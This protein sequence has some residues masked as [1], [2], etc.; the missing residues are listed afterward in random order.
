MEIAMP[1]PLPIHRMK[2][3]ALTVPF[4]TLSA[5]ADPAMVAELQQDEQNYAV[6]RDRLYDEQQTGNTAAALADERNYKLAVIKLREDRGIV[7]GPNA[8]DHQEKQGRNK[9]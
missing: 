4:L 2:L 6:I 5:C 7:N 1:S 9:P 8:H 3:V